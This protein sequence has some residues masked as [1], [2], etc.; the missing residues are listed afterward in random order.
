MSSGHRINVYFDDQSFGVL[1][2]LIN[3]LGEK[4]SPLIR[5]LVLEKGIEAGI[6]S[7]EEVRDSLLSDTKIEYKFTQQQTRFESMLSST[8]R[9]IAEYTDKTEKDIRSLQSQINDLK[10]IDYQVRD[11]MNS[12]MKYSLDDKEELYKSA[13]KNMQDSYDPHICMQKSEE[14]YEKLQER[15]RVE[16]END[17]RRSSHN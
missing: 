6:I 4:Q 3:I 14:N 15:L 12:L 7:V 13:D 17:A 10:K 16:K 5:Q 1:E 8:R 9:E 11:M 2:Q